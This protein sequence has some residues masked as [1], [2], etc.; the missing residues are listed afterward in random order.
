[1]SVKTAPQRE[2]QSRTTMTEY[3]LPT[4]A[5]ALGNVFGG[6]IL[7]WMDI[8]AAICA[9]RHAGVIGVT[10]GVDE[11]SFQRPIKVGQVVRLDARITCTFKTSF[12]IRVVVH[13]EDCF[14]PET[15]LCVEAFLTFVAIDQDNR[16]VPV[17]QLILETPEDLALAHDASERRRLRLERR[18]VRAHK[19]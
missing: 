18:A 11:L 6:Q 16:P 17:P 8:C 4:H 9:Q 13:G 2:A 15:W 10:A 7:A 14:T 1:M 5:N 3:V 19:G 12:E